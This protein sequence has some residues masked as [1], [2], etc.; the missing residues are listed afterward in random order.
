MTYLRRA[1]KSFFYYCILLTVILTAL[2]LLHVTEAN[3]QTLFR[4]GWTSVGEILLIFAIVSA[5]YPRFGYTTKE[6]ILP[7]GQAAVGESGEREVLI[8]VMQNRGY[9]LEEEGDAVWKFRLRNTV[10]RLSRMAEDRITITRT[11]SGFSLEGLTKDVVRL[12]HA[13]E[14]RFVNHSSTL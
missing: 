3:V 8:E 9:K 10:N 7:E 11:T 12:V 2:V 6:A 14:Y 5:I 4:G 1:I 13:I